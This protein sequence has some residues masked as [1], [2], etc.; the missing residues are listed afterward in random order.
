M[1]PITRFNVHTI[2]LPK[3]A[4]NC[5]YIASVLRGCEDLLGDLQGPQ[6]PVGPPGP[7]GFVG[8]TGLAGG[9]C[10]RSSGN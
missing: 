3:S 7:R 10:T 8:P 9:R 4:E 5:G 1:N 2:P 6:G